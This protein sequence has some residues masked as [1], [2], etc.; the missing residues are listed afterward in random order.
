M[1]RSSLKMIKQRKIIRK[2][3]NFYNTTQDKKFKISQNTCKVKRKRKKKVNFC[4]SN[5]QILDAKMCAY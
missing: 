5:P 1:D 4:K 2:L 3:H